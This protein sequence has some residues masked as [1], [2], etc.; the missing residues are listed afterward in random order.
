MGTSIDQLLPK[1]IYDAAINANA[2]TAANPFATMA[3]VGGGGGIYGGS[4][5]LSG[6]TLVTMGVNNLTFAGNQLI[7]LDGTTTLQLGS[8]GGNVIRNAGGD[9]KIEALAGAG[10]NLTLDASQN[11]SINGNISASIAGAANNFIIN[12]IANTFTDGANSKGIIYAADYSANFT[13]RS[14]VDKGYVD[15]AIDVSAVAQTYTPTNVVTDRAYDANSTTLD[16]IAD[17][18]G[19]LIGDLQTS[20]IIL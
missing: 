12:T 13:A 11:V 8:V 17:V 3:D 20:G 10:N 9:L 16:E 15:N 18:L 19:T 14:L 2:P 4:G 6:A 5:S 7:I 1:D